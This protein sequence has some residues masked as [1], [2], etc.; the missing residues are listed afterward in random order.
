MPEQERLREDFKNG[1][2]WMSL[3]RGDP[4]DTKDYKMEFE[5][6]RKSRRPPGFWQEFAKT[7][8]EQL[9]ELDPAL[10]SWVETAAKEGG[11][12]RELSRLAK[13]R[14]GRD[15][16][17]HH[18]IPRA[19]SRKLTPEQ[20]NAP[21]NLMLLSREAHA[22]FDH[23]FYGQ[24]TNWTQPG[25]E[26]R[27]PMA[28]EGR[29]AIS[30]YRELQSLGKEGAELAAL[31]MAKDTIPIKNPGRSGEFEKKL[32]KSYAEALAKAGD[33]T[34]KQQLLTEKQAEEEPRPAATG[35][36]RPGLGATFL[37]M[38]AIAWPKTRGKTR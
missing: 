7:N 15:Y 36:P 35:L 30:F 4:R 13:A 28:G 21:S 6:I 2:S 18:R 38:G 20:V 12:P 23:A 31:G 14:T 11:V 16:D 37:G 10:R 34:A 26:V 19:F 8:G 25:Q 17:F 9:A 5:A 24:M 29:E 33:P 3:Q 27:L 22:A 32:G 1:F